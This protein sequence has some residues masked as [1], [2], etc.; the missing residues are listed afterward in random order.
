MKT[1]ITSIILACALFVGLFVSMPTTAHAS[2]RA[3]FGHSTQNQTVYS[4]PGTSG[5]VTSGSIEK[6]EM[7]WILGKVKN[8]DWY[9]IQYRV[10]VGTYAGK[11]RTGYVP[12]STIDNIGGTGDIH[13]EIY[14]GGERISNSAQ[15]VY[16]CDDMTYRIKIGSISAQEPITLL[17]AYQYVDS[18]KSYLV[19]YIEYSTSS[20]AKRGYLHYPDVTENILGTNG[21]TS[22]ARVVSG[23][24]VYFGRGTSS[25]YTAGSISANEFVTVIAK[26]GDWVYVEYN[27]KNGRKRGHL[28]SGYL[29]Y[30]R[31]GLS[32]IDVYDADPNWQAEGRISGTY[33]VYAGPTKQYAA[34]DTVGPEQVIS[35]QN[36]FGHPS[37]SFI[38]Y[39]EVGVGTT[40]KSG[41]IV[42]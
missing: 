24:T 13:E 4:G 8:M 1:K 17:Y 39:R 5:Y 26:Y 41:W 36:F 31:P 20:G 33:T 21:V 19:A 29:D 25:Y 7:V 15:N 18:S 6:N 28:S 35:Y 37:I 16:S 10:T 9:H 30:H 2:S 38:I 23:A 42:P 14:N 27:T 32:Y 3:I 40:R 34:I 12:I 11:Q 22:V